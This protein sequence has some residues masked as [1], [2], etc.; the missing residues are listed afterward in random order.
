MWL[1][2]KQAAAELERLGG[3]WEHIEIAKNISPDNNF[4]E[5]IDFYVHFVAI[6][7]SDTAGITVADELRQ[8]SDALARR[9]AGRQS[10]PIGLTLVTWYQELVGGSDPEAVYVDTFQNLPEDQRY[11]F[12]VAC[13]RFAHRRSDWD[14]AIE[15]HPHPAEQCTLALLRA[16]EQQ[17][18]G[19]RAADWQQLFDEFRDT[20]FA[21]DV[22]QIAMISGVPKDQVSRMAADSQKSY[23]EPGSLQDSEATMIESRLEYLAQSKSEQW[24]LGRAPDSRNALLQARFQIA[25]MHLAQGASDAL[26]KLR[27][28]TEVFAPWCNEYHWARAIHGWLRL[29]GAEDSASQH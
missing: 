13:Q 22:L 11:S 14:S 27:E 24:L 17:A 5:F 29:G 28:A 1:A 6:L 19:G 7:M 4:V 23:G 2:L 16:V 21:L 18:S 25:M 15:N 9:V 26:E 10:W 8:E 12:P 3:A 20:R